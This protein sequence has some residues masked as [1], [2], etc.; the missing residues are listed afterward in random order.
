MLVFLLLG[1]FK[2]F[3]F[4]VIFGRKGGVW[5][6]LSEGFL[7]VFLFFIMVF[8]DFLEFF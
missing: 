2:C 1:F 4:F 6:G 7:R 3:F 5:R 8:E